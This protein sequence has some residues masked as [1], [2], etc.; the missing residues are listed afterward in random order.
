MKRNN[1]A[2]DAIGAPRQNR[3]TMPK[4]EAP[5][6]GLIGCGGRV[7][8]VLAN[9]LKEDPRIQVVA[10]NDPDATSI[11]AAKKQF[12]PKARV[13]KTFQALAADPEVD[14]IMIGSWNVFHAEH[15]IAALKAGKHVFC[16]KPLATT[17]KDC[18]A[19][20]KA[21]EAGPGMF[22][23]GLVLRYAPLY[24]KVRELLD[25]GT[26]GKILSFEF[27][28]TIAPSHGGAIMSGWRRLRKNAGTHLLEKCCHDI[29][30]ANWLADSI[31]VRVASFGGL[32]FFTPE[33]AFHIKRL[34][35]DKQ[36]NEAYKFNPHVQVLGKL[37]N[38]FTIDKDIVDNQVAILEYANGVRATFH[39][40]SNAGILERRFYI[41]GTEGAIRA[42]AITGIVEWE[43]IGFDTKRK[44]YD[45]RVAG[46]HA[47]GDEVMAGYLAA[48]MT[49]GVAPRV[50][51]HE[52]IRSAIACMGI[53]QAL[54]TGKVV[55]LRPVWK[56]A[57]FGKEVAPRRK[58]A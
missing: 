57:G 7:R 17:Y 23:F 26:V 51:L 30:L 2:I 37:K 5:R 16:E 49:K 20:K 56:Q 27:N 39:A 42:D 40:N 55:D 19:L 10:L 6:V 58:S 45:T 54:D 47:G 29:D 24:R 33:N 53:D 46:G 13:H 35:K 43:R 11:A 32:D 8:Y 41:L 3:K 14:W 34:G 31:P 44:K 1:I 50:G 4:R 15:A 52:A 12:N 22:S 9:I 36:G 25:A 28:E 18:I 38:P 21:V 48:S